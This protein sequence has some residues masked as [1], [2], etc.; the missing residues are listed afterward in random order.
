MSR[1]AAKVEDG[2]IT[3]VIVGTP[4]WAAERLGGVWVGSDTKVGQGWLLVEGQ[5]VPPPAPEIDESEFEDVF[6]S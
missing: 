4:E 1:Y 6:S 2:V 5:I 3:Q